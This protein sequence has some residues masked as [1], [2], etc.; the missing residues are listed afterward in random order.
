MLALRCRLAFVLRGG[1]GQCQRHLLIVRHAGAGSDQYGERNAA[2]SVRRSFGQ[3][4]NHCRS[5]SMNYRLVNQFDLLGSFGRDDGAAALLD[6]PAHPYVTALEPLRFEAGGGEC[7][8]LAFKN[9]DSEITSPAPPKVD[10][11]SGPAFACRQDLALDQREMTPFGLQS[12]QI[13]GLQRG[14]IGIGPMTAALGPRLPF[15][16]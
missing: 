14:E 10:V 5:R 7:V 2:Q 11:Y 4:R 16:G 9:R 6:P 15:S 3:Y 8:L 13:F 12:R 1:L